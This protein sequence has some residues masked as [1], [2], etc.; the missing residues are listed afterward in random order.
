[1]YV[2][3]FRFHTLKLIFQIDT[4][5]SGKGCRNCGQSIELLTHALVRDHDSI[6]LLPLENVPE[7]ALKRRIDRPIEFWSNFPVEFDSDLLSESFSKPFCCFPLSQKAAIL[8]LIFIP[9]NEG[10][11]VFNA[12][13]VY[14][15]VIEIPGLNR[16]ST[17]Y[18]SK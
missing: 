7:T 10:E 11:C 16:V 6:H 2:E 13:E 9:G 15:S 3:P 14:S 8:R 5:M 1:M 4:R 18:K 17:Y 12:K